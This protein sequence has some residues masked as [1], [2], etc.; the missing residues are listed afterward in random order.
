[1]EKGETDEYT[2][3]DNLIARKLE[4]GNVHCVAGH[5]IAVKNAKYGFVGDNEQIILFTLEFENDWLE[6]HSKIVV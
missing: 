5:Q 4:I 2:Y 6:A 3:L 1:M